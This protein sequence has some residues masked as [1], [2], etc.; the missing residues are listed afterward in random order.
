MRKGP[1]AH[2]GHHSAANR[3]APGG[4]LLRTRLAFPLNGA[5]GRS[6]VALS[7]TPS[8]SSQTRK[9]PL[10]LERDPWPWGRRPDAQ[11]ADR[12]HGTQSCEGT[13]HCRGNE[14]TWRLGAP[15]DGSA[16]ARST[17]PREMA[18]ECTQNSTPLR[19]GSHTRPRPARGSR[20][21]NLPFLG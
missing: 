9:R 12:G 2:A 19:T 17:P 15:G 20:P 13:V 8:S 5:P 6:G 21:Q 4:S 1:L 18:D 11:V 7:G 3:E 14:L 16:L 10:G